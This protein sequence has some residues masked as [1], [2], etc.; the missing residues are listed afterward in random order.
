MARPSLTIGRSL[1]TNA[2]IGATSVALATT[3]VPVFL[4]GALST[5]IGDDLGFDEAVTGAIVTGFYLAAAVVAMPLGALTER[6]G[7]GR[8]MRGGVLLSAVGCLVAATLVTTGW[9]LAALMI[10]LGATLPLV[11]TGAA[12]AFTTSVPVGRRGMAFGIKEASVPLASMLAGLSVPLL[13]TT[14]GWRVAFLGGVVVGPLAVVALR[15]AVP[16]DRTRLPATTGSQ[17]RDD[18]PAPT[19]PR[20]RVSLRRSVRLLAASFALA[21][22]GG[23]AVVT[24]LV[25]AAV[26]SGMSGASAGLTLA[27]ASAGGIVARLVAGVVADRRPTTLGPLLVTA[28]LAGAAGTAGL[29]LRPTGAALV[30][31][32]LVALTAGWGWTGLGFTALTQFVP[33]APATAA[34]AG[35]LGL[36]LGGT[37]GP[38]LFGQLAARGSYPLGWSVLAAV[39]FAGA[40]CAYAGLRIDRFMAV[41]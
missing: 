23:A 1:G 33:H 39:F 5:V 36:A 20:G 8:A 32:A 37:I 17:D 40:V 30:A 25:P 28:M 35:I 12:R 4:V 41:D 3:M 13:A 7:A 24:F 6:I 29:A 15:L 27:V 11:D 18:P 16:A 38:T 21:G 31:V 14:V 10:V 26:D 9:Q 19:R 34:G 2:T 22:A